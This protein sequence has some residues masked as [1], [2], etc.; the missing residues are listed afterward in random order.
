MTRTLGGWRFTA[1]LA[2][3]CAA[4]AVIGAPAGAATLRGPRGIVPIH[5]RA[6][7]PF[8]LLGAEGP[9][10]RNVSPSSSIAQLVYQGGPVMRSN[11]VYTIFWQ[12]TLL[13]GANAFP[14]GYKT[15]LEEYFTRVAHASE[16]S[17]ESF[18]NVYSVGT[19]YY[20][21]AGPGTARRYIE[22]RTS[23]PS[24]DGVLDTNAFPAK[25]CVDEA[26]PVC[27]TDAQL[28]E[29]IETVIKS[30]TWTAGPGSIFLLYTPQ[31]VGSCFEAG[32]ESST[33]KCAYS[34]YCAY[35]YAFLTKTGEEVVYANIPYGAVP[36]CDNGARPEG[37]TAGP[38][39]DTSS[40][41]HNEAVTDPTG[42][43]W[44]DNWGSEE[45]AVFGF[46]IADLCVLSTWEAMYGPLAAGS[47]G[48]GTAGAFNQVIDGGHYLL[49]QEW[50]NA[51]TE[52]GGGCEQRLVPAAFTITP[53]AGA[54]TSGAVSFDGSA[55]GGGGTT[56]DEWQW[57][58]GDGTT[59]SSLSPNVSHTYTSSGVYVVTLMVKDASGDT[60]TTSRSVAVGPAPPSNTTTTT[61]TVTTAT[62]PP[63]PTPRAFTASQLAGLLG[64]PKNGARRS[65]LGTI[66]L[67]HAECPPACAV[68]LRIY[69]KL[70]TG[71]GKHRST[72]LVAIGTARMT[73]GAKGA[74]ALVLSLNAKGRAL[75]R[76]RHSLA[77]KLLVTVVGR[78]GGTWQIVR[79][80]TLTSGGSTARRA[81]R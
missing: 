25:E 16:S 37:S 23:F 34:Y 73:F 80:L 64:L 43:G 49:Q 30:E 70:P 81:R 44:W 62:P 21:Q 76:K 28:Q 2:L 10:A 79:S 33:N 74:G 32:A 20:E 26:E 40:H 41:E 4:S 39:I 22:D 60:N 52:T 51:A 57:N 24:G 54:A 45:N 42:R 18:N 14:S 5:G 35:H 38:A 9:R 31:N 27:L 48:Y 66:F 7:T 47:T 77:C 72:K 17:S 61:T 69:A 29:Q 15:V 55:S 75:L 67:G 8:G 12:P 36:Q 71:H 68:A 11:R 53:S 19:E 58:F 3:L 50:S 59:Q 46:E 63:P 56:V 78:E 65:G 6:R 1:I 13:L